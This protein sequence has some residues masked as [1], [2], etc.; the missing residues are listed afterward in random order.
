MTSE[1][2]ALLQRL[3][4]GDADAV[5]AAERRVDAAPG[6]AEAARLRRALVQYYTRAVG[7]RRADFGATHL[8]RDYHAALRHMRV[9][10]RA[11]ADAPPQNVL[12]FYSLLIHTGHLTEALA[13]LEARAAAVPETPAEF[14]LH[15][16]AVLARLRYRLGDFEASEALFRWLLEHALRLWGTRFNGQQER[17]V[18]SALA[19]I[20]RMRINAG[21]PAQ[22]AAFIDGFPRPVVLDIVERTR[23]RAQALIERGLCSDDPA[24]RPVDPDALSVVCVKHGRKYGPEYV[25]RLYAMVRRHLPGGWRF[26]CITD[27]A[28]GLRPEVQT[29]DI[30]KIKVSG[31]WTKIA[32]FDLRLPLGHDTVL[33]LDLDTV[34]VRPLRFVEGL[35]C[36]FHIF[37]H[38]DAP[39]F[40]SSVMLFDRRVAAP[41][42][43][44]LTR[45]DVARLPGDQ[46]WIEECMSNADTFAP[47]A[48]GL[49][50]SLEPDTPL[51]AIT[52]GPMQIVTF[53][54]NPKPHQISTG[55]VPELW[56]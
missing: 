25:N 12:Q 5:D 55:W 22:A 46:E 11:S 45:K 8:S 3:N 1:F 51:E 2:N 24:A 40:N 53:P 54:S 48:I 20:A 19:R 42:F 30:S 50:R 21:H 31:W 35:R 44:R 36:G 6:S 41:I 39:G 27:D 33:Y 23:R 52:G 14:D 7:A 17:F 38:P 4:D 49:Y 47:G 43:E 13:A 10:M 28:Q 16:M 32:M 56:K 18:G 9:L 37:E 15:V 34:V 26:V 29:I